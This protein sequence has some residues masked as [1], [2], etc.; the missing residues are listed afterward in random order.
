MTD[1]FVMGW[2]TIGVVADEIL[3][4]V[5]LLVRIRDLVLLQYMFS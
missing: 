3:P 5:D 4:T 2:V 1:Q